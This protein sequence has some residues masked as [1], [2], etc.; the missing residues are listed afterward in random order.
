ML[1]PAAPSDIDTYR[2]W[3]TAN[4]PIAEPEAAFLGHA[5]DLV[6][7]DSGGNKA[8]P[9]HVVRRSVVYFAVAAAAVAVILPLL[10]FSAISEY[11]GRLVVVAIVGGAVSLFL[12]ASRLGEMLGEKHVV[13]CALGYFG[14]MSISALFAP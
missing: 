11:F 7:L 14:L 6:N 13:I 8:A 4:A 3:M 5:T 2:K 1:A 9:T 10:A 12:G